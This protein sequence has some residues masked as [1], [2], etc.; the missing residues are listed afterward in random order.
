MIGDYDF[1]L[2]GQDEAGE[3]L[4]IY[5][6][7]IG[8]PGC[9][10]NQYYPDEEIVESDIERKA[11]YAMKDGVRIIAVVTVCDLNPLDKDMGHLTWELENPCSLERLAVVPEFHRQGIGAIVLKKVI[12]LAK[13]NGFDGI[14]MLVG[15][16]SYPA[17]GLYNK[18]GFEKCGETH[19]YGNDYYCLRMRF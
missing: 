1:L 10:W 17:L 19:M 7:L 15:K 16:T 2:A 4:G 14:V 6:S 8:A 12:D 13:E 18:Y 9:H 3:I 11:L 5:Q